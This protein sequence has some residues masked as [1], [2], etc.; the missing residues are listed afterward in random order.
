MG[1]GPESLLL[2]AS[3]HQDSQAKEEDCPDADHRLQQGELGKFPTRRA[4]A[5]DLRLRRLCQRLIGDRHASLFMVPAAG[6]FY[7]GM[8]AIAVYSELSL[9]A[10]MQFS[11]RKARLSRSALLTGA[12]G[13]ALV[14][15]GSCRGREEC[16]HWSRRSALRDRGCANP[17]PVHVLRGSH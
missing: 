15:V 8:A 10:L 3:S 13:L 2:E 1:R 7:L 17:C 16:H 4:L 11:W 6:I 12:I 5:D 9:T 14:L